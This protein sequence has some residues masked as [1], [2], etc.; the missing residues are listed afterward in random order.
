[1]N[2][3]R[4]RL[5]YSSPEEIEAE[6]EDSPAVGVLWV[7]RPLHAQVVDQREPEP[8]Q[9]AKRQEQGAR[10]RA[11]GGRRKAGSAGRGH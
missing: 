10:R 8:A 2:R 6:E 5:R 3:R 1:L 11:G 9:H 7:H 4:G